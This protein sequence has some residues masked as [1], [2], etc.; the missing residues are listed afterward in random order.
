MQA[1]ILAG[2]FG[3]RLAPITYTR[4]K[5]MLPLLNK[6]MIG[7]LVDALPAGTDIIVAAN[8]R[9]DQ[10]QDYFDARGISAVINNEPI[11]LGTGGA[12]KFAE[13]FID[14]TF[15]VLNSDI[16]ASI[17][18]RDF[19]RFHR[20]HEAMAT[21]SLWPVENVEE[22]GVVDI[23]DTGRI[24]RFVEKPPRAE[25]PSNLINAGAYCLEPDILDYIE[26]GRLVSMEAE[27]FPR[28]IDDDHPFFGYGFEGYWIDVGRPASYLAATRML[29]E[30]RD[31]SHLV[32]ASEVNG[33]LV[34]TTVGD[35]CVIGEGSMLDT[36]IVYDAC[37]IG[38]GA[39]LDHCIL[40]EK[41]VIGPG[42]VLSHVVVGAE[43][44]VA[45]GAQG[46]NERI[47]TKPVPPAYP[48]KQIGNPLNT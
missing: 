33:T 44:R 1:I 23:D 4:A 2:G 16:I 20:E 47:W 11:P 17:N 35:A 19:I 32:G 21:I 15:L 48:K 26:T 7:H 29:L 6:P 9:N 30:K 28:I 31:K 42:A 13:R 24:S 37:R 39:R 46:T 38:A 14:D 43:E 5:S 3:T 25:A 22:Y 40:A 18:L 27:I 12:V 34:Y 10:I 36:C 8:Y 45:E 41:C